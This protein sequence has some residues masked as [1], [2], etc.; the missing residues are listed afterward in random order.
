MIL[1]TGDTT[2]VYQI[3]AIILE[4]DAILTIHL[5]QL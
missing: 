2:A 5:P 4:Y 3:S 1:C